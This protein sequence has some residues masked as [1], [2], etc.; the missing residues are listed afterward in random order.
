[1]NRKFPW[2]LPG[3]N[4]SWEKQTN[5]WQYKKSEK[6]HLWEKQT[7]WLTVFSSLFSQIINFIL[8]LLQPEHLENRPVEK[9]IT[10][11]ATRAVSREKVSRF[12]S[13]FIENRPFVDFVE[14][15]VI[16]MLKNSTINPV[17]SKLWRLK[18]RICFKLKGQFQ[19]LQKLYKNTW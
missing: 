16:K 19:G 1:M 14:I 11:C 10:K 8:L 2:G 6:A 9:A 7:N 13:S 17:V 12:L 5:W 18:I 15:Q 3:S 4:C